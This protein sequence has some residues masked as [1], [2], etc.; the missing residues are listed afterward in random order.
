MHAWQ[1]GQ[2]AAQSTSVNGMFL[3]LVMLAP[4]RAMLVDRVLVL[5]R[6]AMAPTRQ[7]GIFVPRFLIQD[8]R[9]AQL[10]LVAVH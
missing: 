8:L 7:Q 4:V 1:F 2:P 10:A 5:A 3:Q 6:C 9:Y